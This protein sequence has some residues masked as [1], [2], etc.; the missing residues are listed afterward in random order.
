LRNS[1]SEAFIP[2]RM[3]MSDMWLQENI[4]QFM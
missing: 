1:P 3:K 4:W 2:T